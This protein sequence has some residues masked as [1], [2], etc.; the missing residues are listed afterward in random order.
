MEST[1][2]EIYGGRATIEFHPLKHFYTVT[3]PRVCDRAYQPGVTTIIGMKDKSRALLPWAVNTMSERAK[4]LIQCVAESD[5]NKEIAVAIVDAA[6]D[7]Y[8]K[9]RES[10]AEIGS[11]AHDVLERVLMSRYGICD[12]PVL[13]LTEWPGMNAEQVEMANKS[14]KAGLRFIKAHN[15]RVLQAEAPRWSATY[16]YVGTG[17]LVAE[18]DGELAILDWKTGKHIY[19]EYFLQTAAYQKAYE[20]EFPD[21]KI[22]KRWIVNIGRDGKLAHEVRG[23]DT[24]DVDFGCFLSL[25][26]LWRWDQTNQGAYSKPATLIVGPLAA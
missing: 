6:K 9:K 15:I 5:F 20:E 2:T 11:V 19:A 14:I 25:L 7:T 26:N 18:V 13:P 17:D 8:R 12:E 1:A 10:A 4:E 3:V 24:V 21:Q 23:N 22:I 16:G